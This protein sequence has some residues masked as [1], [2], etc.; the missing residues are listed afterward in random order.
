[1]AIPIASPR[2]SLIEM[3]EHDTD[4]M[5]F[6]H[7]FQRQRDWVYGHW[8]S[9]DFMKIFVNYVIVLCDDFIFTVIFFGYYS[10]NICIN[11]RKLLA[12]FIFKSAAVFS[13][14]NATVDGFYLVLVCD[15]YILMRTEI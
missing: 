5:S 7:D 12:Y 1:M 4:I 10:D 2:A 14:K 13:A 3:C 6:E 9:A 11:H 8:R 15:I